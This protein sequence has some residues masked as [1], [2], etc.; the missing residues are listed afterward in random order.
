MEITAISKKSFPPIVDGNAEVLIL[1]SLP[2]ERSLQLQQYYGHKGN[3]FWDIIGVVFTGASIKNFTYGEKT[4]FLHKHKIAL[5]DICGS[6]KRDGSG[7]QNI[8]DVTP[9]DIVGLLSQYPNIK[10]VFVTSGKSEKT[11]TQFFPQ[12]AYGKLPS[13][14]SRY[15][16]KL[17]QKIEIWR[18]ALLSAIRKFNGI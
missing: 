16:I 11:L 2:G 15:P 14:S 7:D 18:A 10:K 9:N 3:Q 13:P 17:E 1:G 6:A 8:R 4:E 12:I 5:W